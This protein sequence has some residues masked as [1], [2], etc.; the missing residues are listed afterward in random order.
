METY[1]HLSQGKVRI[2]LYLR[3]EFQTSTSISVPM[4]PISELASPFTPSILYGY[5]L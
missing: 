4:T 5:L 2:I 1:F 3:S